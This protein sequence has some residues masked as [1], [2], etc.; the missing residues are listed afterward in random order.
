M[1]LKIKNM[2]RALFMS[3]SAQNFKRTQDGIIVNLDKSKSDGAAKLQL[4]IL[5]DDIVQVLA[6]PGNNLKEPI[7][8]CVENKEWPQVVFASGSF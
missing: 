4:K 8:L 5:S 6:Y 3:S 1:Q 7:S 2:L